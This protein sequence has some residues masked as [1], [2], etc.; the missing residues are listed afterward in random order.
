MRTYLDPVLGQCDPGRAFKEAITREASAL[1]PRRQ[2]LLSQ[3]GCLVIAPDL[4]VPVGSIVLRW[5]RT[6]GEASEA[7][8]WTN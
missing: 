1:Y 5:G 4:A 8:T 3:A 6:D 7:R 2:R